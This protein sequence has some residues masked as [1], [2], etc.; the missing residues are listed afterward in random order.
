M[1]EI[2]EGSLITKLLYILCITGEFPMCSISLL[3]TYQSHKRLI[4]KATEQSEYYNPKT[5][6]RYTTRL[7]TVVGKGNKKTLRMLSG[8]Q[9]ILRWL[10]LSELYDSLHGEYRFT[11]KIAER[12]RR[13]RVAEGYAMAYLAGLEI[14]PIEIPKLQQETIKNLFLDRQCFYGSKPLKEVSKLELKKNI[15]TR[16]IGAVFANKN[17]YPVYNTRNEVMKWNGKGERKTLM[18]LEEI[19]RMNAEIY[20]INRAILFGKNNQIA[21]KTLENTGKSK[22]LEFC[23]DDI[24]PHL[25]FI[26]LNEN[27][28]RQ[29]RILLLED[30]REEL[31]SILFTDDVRSFD[32]GSFEYDAKLKQKF[33]LEFFDGDLTRLQRV[34]FALQNIKVEY[35]VLCF[36]FQ[37]DIVK[38]YL[39]DLVKIKTVGLEVIEN[40]LGIGGEN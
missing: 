13:H 27:G 21:L 6:E 18:N 25:Y 28:V 17:V 22:R 8:V 34:R 31:L 20:K 12:E 26:P 2:R 24:Y 9:P 30:W 29:L 10:D 16:I 23:F 1:I 5:K 3:G 4:S 14:N 39:G 32:K 7:L 11:G 36:P 35:E 37:V 15:Y 33:I 40:A 38:E 19:A